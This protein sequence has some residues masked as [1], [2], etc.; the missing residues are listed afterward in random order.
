[1]R[2]YI[3]IEVRFEE[4][5]CA[6]T[7]LGTAI[8]YQINRAIVC[9]SLDISLPI[10]DDLHPLR[11]IAVRVMSRQSRTKEETGLAPGL[12]PLMRRVLVSAATSATRLARQLQKARA[13][14]RQPLMPALEKSLGGAAFW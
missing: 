5:A 3:V 7:L 14:Q 9:M 11:I 2:S 12:F 1:M 4:S 6:S 8:N 13:C 10:S